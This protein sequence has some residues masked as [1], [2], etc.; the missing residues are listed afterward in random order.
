VGRATNAIISGGHNREFRVPIEEILTW[1]PGDFVRECYK[2]PSDSYY[3]TC[4]STKAQWTYVLDIDKSDDRYYDIYNSI[5][6]SGF[7]APLRAKISE[8]D[9]V[10]VLDGHNRLGVA[11]DLSVGEV[12]VYVGSV[13]WIPEDLIAADSGVWQKHQK[14]WVAIIGK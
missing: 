14:P 13:D 8:N 5:K 9:H 2:C 10:V 6:T 1:Y 11:L 3:H 7:V 4:I 12:P